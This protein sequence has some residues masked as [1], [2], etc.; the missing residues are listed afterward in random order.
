MYLRHTGFWGFGA[1]G[2]GCS[3][4]HPSD[5]PAPRA[6]GKAKAKAKADAQS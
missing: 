3:L 1:L 4:Q 6:K 5:G 2:A